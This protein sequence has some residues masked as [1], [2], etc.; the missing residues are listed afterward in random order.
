ML[1]NPKHLVNLF[2]LSFFFFFFIFYWL[3][4][5]IFIG[6]VS[7]RILGVTFFKSVFHETDIFLFKKK[8]RKKKIFFSHPVWGY[9]EALCPVNLMHNPPLS[10]NASLVPSGPPRGVQVEVV[11]STT[12]K[13]MWRT[14]VAKQQHGQIR[15]YQVT[16]I[17]LIRDE[18]VGQPCI[19]DLLTGG[20]KVS[21]THSI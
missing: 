16:Y 4:F 1:W 15:G 21:H 12:A 19:R 9:H 17:R 10:H 6:Y 3:S 8:K 18:P 14:P 20:S 5:S 7:S 11:N 2:F 13:V